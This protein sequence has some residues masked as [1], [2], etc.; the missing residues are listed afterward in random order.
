MNYLVEGFSFII[1]LLPLIAAQ[2]Y[3]PL[4][5]FSLSSDCSPSL[6]LSS[7]F[8]LFLLDRTKILMT[9]PR[10]KD[11]APLLLSSTLLRTVAS[12]L[13]S[14]S[15]SLSLSFSFSSLQM[16]VC[17]SLGMHPCCLYR[18]P[19]NLYPFISL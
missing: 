18:Q 16:M 2:R 4:L 3:K 8:S 12:P 1:F 11:R 6:P 13:F 14:L 19:A 10:E 5:V 7:F 15:L 9:S 17:E